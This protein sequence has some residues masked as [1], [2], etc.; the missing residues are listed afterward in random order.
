MSMVVEVGAEVA[1]VL[2]LVHSDPLK[3][4]QD[5]PIAPRILARRYS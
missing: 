2:A 3:Y 5:H 1:A 4:P